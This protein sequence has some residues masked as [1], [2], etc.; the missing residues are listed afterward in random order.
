MEPGFDLSRQELIA[1]LRSE[2][3]EH[4][5]MPRLSIA[6]PIDK[7]AVSGTRIDFP[8]CSGI[9]LMWSGQVVHCVGIASTI[10]GLELY[11]ASDEE[12]DSLLPL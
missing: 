11:S 2:Q 5:A 1:K 8:D 10:D 9:E 12:L 4:E 6:V 7:A 3:A